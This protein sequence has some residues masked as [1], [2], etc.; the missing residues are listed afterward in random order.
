MK[1]QNIKVSDAK[2][3]ETNV[4]GRTEG[5]AF[6][7]LV[8]SVKEKGVLVPV[9]ARPIAG[10]KFEV[11]AGNRRLAAARKA[12]LVEI[13]AMIKEMTDVEAREAQI[14]ENLQREDVH[15]LDEGEAYRQLVEKSRYE[16]PAVAAKVGK[17]ESYV[18]QRLFLTNLEEKPAAAYRAGKFSD[19]HAVLIARLGTTDQIS[20]LKYVSDRYMPP[21]LKDLNEWIKDHIYSSLDF[22]PWLKS[23]ELQKIVGGCKECEPSRASLFGAVTAGA[24]TDLKCWTRKMDAHIEHR[25]KTEKLVKIRTEYGEHPKGM[26]GYGDFVALSSNQKLHCAT[27]RRAIVAHGKGVGS[28]MWI[29]SDSECKRHNGDRS[30]YKQTPEERAKRKKEIATQKTREENKYKA[31][32]GTI[33]R[34][35]KWP[36]SEKCLDVLIEDAIDHHGMTSLMSV[37]RRLGFKISKEKHSWGGT[38]NSYKPALREWLSKAGKEERLRMYFELRLRE[39]QVKSL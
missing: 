16:I 8:S 19:G 31:F 10:G 12:G 22:Q 6:V 24:C 27:T 2:H 13:P 18:K 17:S 35:V 34:K 20:A 36:L 33:E 21:S 28:L 3:S 29:C 4:E 7:D 5:A 15:P 26:L 23:V 32:V 9:L 1:L 39:E 38:S 25:S 37:A 11:V 14:I 30:A